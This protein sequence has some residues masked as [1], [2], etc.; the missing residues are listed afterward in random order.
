MLMHVRYKPLIAPNRGLLYRQ[1]TSVYTVHHISTVGYVRCLL[2][3][4][5]PHPRSRNI[6]IRTH[7]SRQPCSPADLEE[8]V[9]Y[10]EVKL[11][12]LTKVLKRSRIGAFR[13]SVRYDTLIGDRMTTRHSG[14]RRTLSRLAVSTHAWQIGNPCSAFKHA[15]TGC[16][17]D[18]Q[19]LSSNRRGTS[20]TSSARL[21]TGRSLHCEIIQT[22]TCCPSRLST[23]PSSWAST[24]NANVLPWRVGRCTDDFWSCKSA[25]R[26]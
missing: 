4:I 7:S 1:N 25:D 13:K 24:C 23:W 15:L 9:Q 19:R 3:C 6:L 16:R 21:W 8:I 17:P 11:A 10:A 12:V 26:S 20:T 5:E 18:P 14:R 2:C 22:H